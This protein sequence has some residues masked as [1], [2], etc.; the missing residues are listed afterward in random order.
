[1]KFIRSLGAI[2][3]LLA[4]FA[5]QLSAQPT[6]AERREFEAVKARADRGNGEAQLDVSTRYL[7]GNGVDRDVKKALK[8]LR[9]AA[10]SGVPRA[11]CLLGLAFSSGD[12]VKLDK[13]E[14]VRWLRRA[15]EKGLAEAQYDL[16][17]CFANGDGV[18]KNAVEAIEWYRKA[19]E[20][21]LPE[22]EAELGSC[23]LDGLGVPKDIPEGVRWTR[24]AAEHGFAPAQN[25]FGLCYLKG[26][27]V[28]KSN[29]EAYKW[30]A[31][32]AAKGDE[33]AD[34]A[35][36]NLAS[37]ERFLTP[38]Q[39]AEAQQMAHDFK[40]YKG[41][42]P[43]ESATQ[44]A[45]AAP[46]PAGTGTGQTNAVATATLPGA[47]ANTGFVNVKAEDDS[48]EIF[49]DGAFVGNAPA[50]VKLAEGA[51]VVEVKK[52]GYKAYRRQIKITEGSELTL[53][54]VL[55]KE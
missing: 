47:P 30:F 52:L 22:A 34:D 15:A 48:Y 3:L 5:V 19:A 24:R 7:T 40:P 26:K 23:Y 42:K 43:A 53:R 55:E 54:A 17:M 49:V 44:P 45:K 36:L 46:H 12:G 35:R 29:T 14:G 51:H 21:Y 28:T 11:Q 20:Q 32:A 8:Y 31:L 38:E 10:D 4:G 25:T 41:P 13:A 33:R 37:A 1:M 39:V 16:G 9:K 18:P 27:G 50:K 6:S 2:L